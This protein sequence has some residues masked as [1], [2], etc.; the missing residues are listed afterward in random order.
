[1]LLRWQPAGTS[2]TLPPTPRRQTVAVGN[3]VACL[4]RWVNEHRCAR[5][6]AVR[7]LTDTD[8]LVKQIYGFTSLV[9]T[10]TCSMYG[11]A[12]KPRK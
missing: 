10:Y 6:A 7:F 8:I 2:S 5:F 12:Y 4:V 3:L 9:F 11:H 1:M